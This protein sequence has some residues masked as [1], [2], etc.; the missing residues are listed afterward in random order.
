MDHA[1]TDSYA[2]HELAKVNQESDLLRIK[3]ADA[4]E[5]ETRWMSITPETFTKIADI[6]RQAP[7][8]QW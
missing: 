3:V 7:E 5:G 8:M 6:L 2:D 1:V 4:F